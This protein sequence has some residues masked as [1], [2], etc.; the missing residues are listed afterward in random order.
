MRRNAIFVQYGNATDDSTFRLAVP[1]SDYFIGAS[2]DPRRGWADFL[3][4]A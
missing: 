2:K 3:L 1:L 4:G